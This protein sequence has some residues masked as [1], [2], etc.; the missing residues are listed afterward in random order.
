M[1]TRTGKIAP[2]TGETYYHQVYELVSM[3]PKGQVATYGQIADYIAGCTPRMVGYALFHLNASTRVPWQRVINAKGEIS[4]RPG[5][6]GSG[7]QRE[8]LEAE[9]VAFDVFGKTD[10]KRYRWGGPPLKWLMARGL[11]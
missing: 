5:E 10:L 3:I 2:K 7:S 4:P 8:L 9:G 1:M 6:G 11:L